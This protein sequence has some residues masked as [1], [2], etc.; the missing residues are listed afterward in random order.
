MDADGMPVEW[1]RDE[2]PLGYGYYPADGAIEIAIARPAIP[3]LY[4]V[5]LGA[6]IRAGGPLA[7]EFWFQRAPD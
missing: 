1:L 5:Q 6:R 7:T 3:G 2:E 4:R